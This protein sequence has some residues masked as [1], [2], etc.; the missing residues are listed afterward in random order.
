M[1][2]KVLIANRG[3]IAVRIASS[4][5]ALGLAT[6]LVVANDDIGAYPSLFVDETIVLDG[7]DLTSTYLHI[8]AIV[9]AAKLVGADCVHPG[10][11]F[12][13]EN[14]AFAR[15]VEAAGLTFIGP[16]ASVIEQMGSKLESKRLMASVGVPVL[17]GAP[18]TTAE[19]LVSLS[20]RVGWP[21]LIKAS[22]GGGGRGMRI[23]RSE[24]EAGPAIEAAFREALA[25]FGDGT[26][27][28]ERYL[29]H[30]RHIEVQIFGDHHGNLVDLFERDCSVQRRHQK[31]IEESPAPNLDPE[32]RTALRSAARLAGTTVGYVGAGTVE[33]I[34]DR[35]G[36]F[37]FL[38][39]NTRL[40]VEH[41][42]TEAVTGVDL[43][44]WQFRVAS[45][46]PLGLEFNNAA[47]NGFA[48]EARLCA[49]DPRNGFLPQ[50]GD[51]DT[52]F[53]GFT[54]RV[55]AGMAGGKVSSRYDPLLAKFIAHGATRNEA[56]TE[57][58]AALRSWRGVGIPTNR[59]LL[60]AVLEDSQF[61]A[62]GVP[63][64]FLDTHDPVELCDRVTTS[65][66]HL[67]AAAGVAWLAAVGGHTNLDGQ[68]PIGFRNVGPRQ[69]QLIVREGG[70]QAT[71][72]YTARVGG[73]AVVINGVTYAI[74]GL[75]TT[76]LEHRPIGLYR[77][78]EV[79][80]AYEDDVTIA[81]VEISKRR[82]VVACAEDQCLVEI[83]ERFDV[84]TTSVAT[85]SLV[86][87]MPGLLTRIEVGV[88]DEVVA[89]Q[90]L[91]VMEAMKMEHVVR[92]PFNGTVVAI[93]VTA[94]TQVEAGQLLVEL[95]ERNE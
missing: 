41:P 74:A 95:G 23:V 65:R 46:E 17:D 36:T 21:L 94:G 82:V 3:E 89:G 18:V 35:D 40:Q 54:V 87:A 88:G 92:A 51:L 48:I 61:L 39:M 68:I 6:A 9:G 50:A 42:V 53:E 81:T 15:A 12:L 64:S 72:S 60:V 75:A 28:A 34:V 27:L 44:E 7:D 69:G 73:V 66:H 59:D 31:L 13:S 4:A 33:F 22:A 30:P 32:V 19:D 70:A 86:S 47:A 58:A 80:G 77:R 26:L 93:S 90:G 63:T 8:Q 25:A 5:R 79:K 29:E 37:A 71:L 49:E 55:D 10:Y 78:F 67:L 57:L 2:K 43:V 62:G 16:S 56:A 76:D 24:S 91:I 14:A 11:G 83:A 38:E 20:A 45:R 85:G 84:G 1:L 52:D